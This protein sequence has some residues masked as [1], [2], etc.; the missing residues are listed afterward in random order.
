MIE[1]RVTAETKYRVGLSFFEGIG[2]IR[3][4]ALYD[5]FGSAEAIYKASKLDLLETR[6]GNALIGRFVSFRS[7]FDLDGFIDNFQKQGI[8]VISK[9]DKQYPSALQEY[10]D[11]PFILY[12]IGDILLLNK[13]RLFAVVGT[14]KPTQYGV[15]VTKM[16]STDL[17]R[18]GFVVVSGMAMG[19]DAVAHRAALD[20][21]GTTIAVLGCG[22]D[23]CYPA[24]NRSLYED[25]KKRGLVL[26]EFPPG[27][28]TGRGVFP[29]RNRIVA[30]LSKGI[31][32]TEGATKSGSLITARYGSDYGKDMFA[33]PGPITSDMSGATTWL[34]QNG[35]KATRTIDDILEEYDRVSGGEKQIVTKSLI[36]E[37]SEHERALVGF[38]QDQGSAHTDTIARQVG[39]PVSETLGLISSLEMKGILVEVARSEYAVG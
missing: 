36:Q 3:F 12:G 16:F 18:S 6:I 33:V 21:G 29:S 23:I 10:P 25:I 4:Q 19:V 39:F 28:R 5:Y 37:L 8:F 2:P 14:R 38:V 20:A 32:V 11:A 31:L 7:S 17:T 30:G 26:S 9:L 15:S 22:V 27:K 1:T 24:V 13:P 35:A 34:L